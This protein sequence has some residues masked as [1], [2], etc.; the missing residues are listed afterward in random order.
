MSI[1][2]VADIDT[3][4]VNHLDI[5]ELRNLYQINTYYRNLIRPSLDS[6]IKFFSEKVR[7]MSRSG[8]YIE[9]VKY[10]NIEI[11]KY[12]QKYNNS[13]NCNV[14]PVA[15]AYGH[16][17]IAKLLHQAVWCCCNGKIIHVFEE[18]CL[19]DHLDVAKWLYTEIK[20]IPFYVAFEE[21]CKYCNNFDMIKWLDAILKTKDYHKAFSNSCIGGKLETAQYLYSQYSHYLHNSLNIPFQDACINNHLDVAK[22]LHSLGVNIRHNNDIAFKSSCNE[23][24]IDIIH[25]LCSMEPRYSAEPIINYRAII[26]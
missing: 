18:T 1:F 8:Q 14:F 11:V 15:C 17:N 7:K 9:S 21:C 23:N 25:W 16:L 12:L 10:G 5:D 3:I 22:W 20:N 4:L 6:F 24:A 26:N 2:K 13:C 19:N